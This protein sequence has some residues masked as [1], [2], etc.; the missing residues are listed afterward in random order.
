MVYVSALGGRGEIRLTCVESQM[1]VIKGDRHV[2][3]G[4][5]KV[6]SSRH[7]AW[8]RR[9]LGGCLDPRVRAVWLLVKD[10][11]WELTRSHERIEMGYEETLGMK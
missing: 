7:M 5:S 6:C 11:F 2:L 10:T 8:G 4:G 9:A 1:A 3:G